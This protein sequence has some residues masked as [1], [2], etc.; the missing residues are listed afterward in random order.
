MPIKELNKTALWTVLRFF[1]FLNLGM[2]AIHF[3]YLARGQYVAVWGGGTTLPT[4]SPTLKMTQW[5][6][7][8][9]ESIYFKSQNNQAEIGYCEKKKKQR[10]GGTLARIK[11]LE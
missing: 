7:F 3:P 8:R 11:W 6:L 5:I 1:F 9:T 10:L 2:N 4:Y